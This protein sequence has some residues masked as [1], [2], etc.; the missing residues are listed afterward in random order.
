MS[1]VG[2]FLKI[3]I[4]LFKRGEERERNINVTEKHRSVASCMHPDWGPNPQSR[5]CTLTGNRTGDL[6]LCRRTP[7]Q[8]RHITQGKS[9]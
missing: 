3:F 9:G 1:K 7:K 5:H 6:L 2:K 8:L 4:Y